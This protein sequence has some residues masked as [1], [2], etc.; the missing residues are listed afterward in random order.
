LYPSAPS[1]R[2]T[3]DLPVPDIPVSKTRPTIPSLRFAAGRSDV[4]REAGSPARQPLCCLIQ[5]IPIRIVVTAAERVPRP[6]RSAVRAG[7]V[8]RDPSG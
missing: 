2:I 1:S 5:N 6:R 7:L 8:T 4:P 3:L